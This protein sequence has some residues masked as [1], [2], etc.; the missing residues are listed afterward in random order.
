MPYIVTAPFWQ[1]VDHWQTLIA[2]AFALIAGAIAYIAGLQQ[3]FATTR[4]SRNQLAAAARKDRLQ[5][6]CIA[7]GIAPKLDALRIAR[8]NSSRMID[9]VAELDQSTSMIAHK[10]VS[11]ACIKIPP[12]LARNID[13]LYLL[14]EPTGPTILQLVFVIL[15]YNHM[16]QSLAQR[17]KEH[18]H[19]IDPPKHK[20]DC[21]GHLKMIGELID[22]ADS[23]IEGLHS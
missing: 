1:F 7:V 9:A 18:P 16:L 13:H 2:G 23:E 8:G 5:A 14:G 22:A 17:L 3:A 19:F 6:R 12:I 15:Q 10:F 11:D 20:K 21:S 4:S